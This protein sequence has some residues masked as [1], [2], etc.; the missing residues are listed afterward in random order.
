[1]GEVGLFSLVAAGRVLGGARS[2]S[3]R[4]RQ[5]LAMFFAPLAIHSFEEPAFGAYGELRADLVRR[6]TPI[7]SHD[8][9]IDA[10]TLSQH[11]SLIV[12]NTRE[13][14]S[15]PGLQVENWLTVA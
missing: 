13:L 5:A 12:T 8:T 4:N 1:M 15:V 3:A 2:G 11:S 14:A 9:M 6:G 7:S 10:Q